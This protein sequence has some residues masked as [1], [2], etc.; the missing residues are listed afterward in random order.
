MPLSG[1]GKA[2]GKDN[3]VQSLIVLIQKKVSLNSNIIDEICK[4][5]QQGFLS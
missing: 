4:V 3:W 2:K 5:L 1:A